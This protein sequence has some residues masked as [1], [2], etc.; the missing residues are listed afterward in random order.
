MDLRPFTAPIVIV[1]S[2][3]IAEQ[4]TRASKSFPWSLP[5]SPTML[6]MRDLVGH[7]SILAIGVSA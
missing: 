1:L 3:D 2:Y 6:E 5:K 4:V 7:N